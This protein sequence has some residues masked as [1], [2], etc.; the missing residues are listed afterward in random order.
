MHKYS[1]I[2]YLL[3][4]VENKYLERLLFN[5][6]E[7]SKCLITAIVSDCQRIK[8]VMW[9]IEANMYANK[10]LLA[11]SVESFDNSLEIHSS[12]GITYVINVVAK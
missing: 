8:P 6:V 7:T 12:D 1:I 5:K 2:H 10:S 3:D 11:I 4:A 9:M